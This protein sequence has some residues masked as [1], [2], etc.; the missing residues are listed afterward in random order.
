MSGHLTEKVIII[1]GAASGF[2]ALIAEKCAA[3]GARV[4]GVDVNEAGLGAVILSL[5]HI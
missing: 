1:T 3:G 2:G 4:V 5:I